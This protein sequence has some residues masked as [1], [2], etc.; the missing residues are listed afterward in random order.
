MSV[1]QIGFEPDGTYLGKSGGKVGF[2]GVT[3]VVQRTL[4]ANAAPT[5]P[6][7]SGSTFVASIQSI[8]VYAATE[9]DLIKTALR[10]LGLGV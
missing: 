9:V 6:A 5:Q 3:P 7:A 4:N 1:S 8:A 2:F 10:Q